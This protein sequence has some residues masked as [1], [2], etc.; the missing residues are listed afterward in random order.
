MWKWKCE[1]ESGEG[2][3]CDWIYLFPFITICLPSLG[4]ALTTLNWKMKRDAI[5]KKTQYL[6]KWFSS[7]SNV[8]ENSHTCVSRQQEVK[9]WGQSPGLTSQRAEEKRRKNR[10]RAEGKWRKNRKTGHSYQGSSCEWVRMKNWLDRRIE[11]S[12]ERWLRNADCQH[13]SFLNTMVNW[14]HIRWE[15]ELEKDEQSALLGE[16]PLPRRTLRRLERQGNVFV[17]WLQLYIYNHCC[18]FFVFLPLFHDANNNQ[19]QGKFPICSSCLIF[20]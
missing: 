5:H 9:R 20:V 4:I 7:E 6:T 12:L 16:A 13:L 15:G 18:Q 3:T 2:Q 10:N 11:E 19:A 14:H 8:L 17:C 1:S